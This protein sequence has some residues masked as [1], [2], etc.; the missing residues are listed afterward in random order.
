MEKTNREGVYVTHGQKKLIGQKA[1]V[2][3]ELS[4]A[5]VKGNEMIGYVSW[6]DLCRQMMSG[7][8]LEFSV[9]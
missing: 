6:E 7:P 5:Y 9:N 3:G 2:N 4:I 1:R 8:Y